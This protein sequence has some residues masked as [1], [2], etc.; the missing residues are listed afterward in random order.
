MGDIE[1]NV[2]NFMPAVKKTESSAAASTSAS[3]CACAVTHRIKKKILLIAV[4]TFF[5]L[6]TVS[7]ILIICI[8]TK[9]L[10]LKADCNSSAFDHKLV[11]E[12]CAALSA[13]SASELRQFCSLFSLNS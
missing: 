11:V 7:S 10:G 9:G 3:T 5:L 2:A 1:L 6:L 13:S 4:A 8:V 12:F